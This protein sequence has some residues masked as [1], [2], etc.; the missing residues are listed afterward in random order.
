MRSKELSSD[1]ARVSIVYLGLSVQ[2]LSTYS[3]RLFGQYYRLEAAAGQYRGEDCSEL[4]MCHGRSQL[5]CNVL[6]CQE[7]RQCKSSLAMYHHGTA[8]LLPYREGCVCHYGHFICM[9]PPAG[10][11]RGKQTL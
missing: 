2:L 11:M 8:G 1:E 4:C 6:D 9:R 7:K 5:V 10:E 3:L